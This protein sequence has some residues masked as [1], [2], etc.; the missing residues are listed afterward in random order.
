MV[1]DEQ[2][3]AQRRPVAQ[4]EMAPQRGGEPGGAGAGGAGQVIAQVEAEFAI[5]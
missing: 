1:G 2:H 4:A 5:R 3:E